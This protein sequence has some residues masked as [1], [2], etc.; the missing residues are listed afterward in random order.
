MNLFFE[1]QKIPYQ[2]SFLE[3]ETER[4]TFKIVLNKLWAERKQFG[5]TSVYFDEEEHQEQQFFTF[6]DTF[7]KAG[8]YIG[9]I[10]Y[11]NETIQILPKI[12]EN[13]TTSYSKIELLEISNKNL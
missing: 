1:Y 9:T 5:L 8:K 13:G 10:K 3:D 6:Y 7:V 2:G 4:E 12:L 11:G